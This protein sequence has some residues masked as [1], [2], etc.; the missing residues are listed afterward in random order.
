[1]DEIRA[2]MAA[3]TWER[4]KGELRALVV[5]QGHRRLTDRLPATLAEDEA[6]SARWRSFQDRVEAF[7]RAV[8]DDGLHE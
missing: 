2:M 3:A 8:E 5:I 6:R 7:V 1:M 4:A